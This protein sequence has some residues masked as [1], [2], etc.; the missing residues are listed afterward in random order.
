MVVG[1]IIAKLN[2]VKTKDSIVFSK[3]SLYLLMPSA[4]LNAFNFKPSNEVIRGLTVSFICAIVIHIILYFL[5]LLYGKFVN[6]SPVERASVM[7]S[8]AGSLIIPIVTFVLGGEWVIYSTGFLTVQLFFL[9]SHGVRL[10]SSQEKF[11]VKKILL[12]VNMIAIALG[13]ILMLIGISLP[14][15]ASEITSSFG[16]MLGPIGMLI[17][18]MLAADIDFKRIFTN[19]K[20]YRVIAIKMVIYPCVMLG[21]LKLF[22][23]LPILNIEKL[24]LISYLAIIT[25]SASS[26]LQFAQIHDRDAD[27][28][29]SINIFTAVICVVTMPLFV[30]LFEL[31]V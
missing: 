3:I 13:L 20:I 8:N 14:K 10:F 16:S 9:W 2:I 5:D 19:I 22:S 24:L 12:N 30:A 29:T 31:L 25:P 7:Y 26:V 28:A 1:F 21:V 6:K 15:F 23:L 18:G 27:Y 17:A 11:N 4:I